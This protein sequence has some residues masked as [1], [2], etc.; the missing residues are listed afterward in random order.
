MKGK[1]RIV[2]QN[3]RLH[4][5]FE[6]KRNI[7]I[8]KGDSATGK[9]NLINMLRAAENLGNGS[10]VTVSCDV[11]CR[12]LEGS[13]WNIILNAAQK[14]I[15]FTDEEN[16]FIRTEAFASAVN[17]SDNYFV[18]ITRESLFNLPYS[19]DEIYGLHSSGRYQN[20]QQIYQQFYRI[21]PDTLHE[22]VHPD[23][24]LTED[25]NAGF[26][27]FHAVSLDSGIKCESANGK[28]GIYRSL[29]QMACAMPE[30]EI[31][32]IADGAAI[33]PEM[34]RLYALVRN[35]SKLKLFLPES[36][37][38]L[39][40]KSGLIHEKKLE[41]I[42][43]LPENFIDS[44]EYMSWERFFTKLLTDSSS[45]TYLQYSKSKLNEVYLHDK[46]RA[47]ILHQ[48]RMIRFNR[49]TQSLP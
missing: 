42:L 25:S 6:I 1:H 36:F 40:L 37:E 39:I 47:K 41:A 48:I 20:T 44:R 12:V 26:E 31:C 32:V 18:L 3:N 2:V 46:N 45:G 13:N 21:Y 11:P 15:F 8:L 28:S 17:G 35:N 14:T 29:K 34:N 27:F 10:G 23:C 7:T 24:I 4:Y 19:V 16:Y 5:E 38:W 9:T 22:P 49:Q 33:G 30:C 43:E